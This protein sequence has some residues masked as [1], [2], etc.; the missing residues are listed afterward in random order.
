MT[1]VHTCALPSYACTA[2]AEHIAGS[3][4][5]FVKLMNEKAKILG[6]YHDQGVMN[7]ERYLE[8]CNYGKY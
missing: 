5:G 4:E 6:T 3:E 2:L 7:K 1:G 8:V